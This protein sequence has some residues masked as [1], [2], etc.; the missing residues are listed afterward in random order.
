MC[1][2]W[3][4]VMGFVCEDDKNIG[5]RRRPFS[6]LWVGCFVRVCGFGGP[7]R[8]ALE[9]DAHRHFFCA[10]HTRMPYLYHIF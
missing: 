4:Y 8:D 3:V 10:C 5:A 2:C 1:V 9:E 6:F 7:A